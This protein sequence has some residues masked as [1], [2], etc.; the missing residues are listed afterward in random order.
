MI[1]KKIALIIDTKGWSFDYI[2][3]QVKKYIEEYDIDIIPG[4]IFN[5]NIAKLF[6]YCENYDL[7]HFMWRGYIS[8]IDSEMCKEY[9]NNLGYDYEYFKKKYILCKKISFQIP[10]Q[11]FLEGKDEWRTKKIMEYSKNYFVTSMNLQKIYN[12]FDIKPKKIIH[13]P[14]N[15]DLFNMKNESRFDK[16]ETLKLCWCGN[17]KFKDSTGDDDLKGVNGIIKPAV[18]ELQKE[19]YNIELD[20]IDREINGIP[21]EQMP[22]FY[23]N[24]HVYIC[25]SKTEGT[26]LTILEAMATGL[27]IISTDVG[28][29]REAL[30]KKQS[31]YILEERSRDCLKQKIIELINNKEEIKELSM[32][33]R[34]RI[35][36][37]NSEEIAKQYKGF[38][39][40]ILN[41]N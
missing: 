33:N 15:L 22:K 10:D 12:Q 37:F 30:G 34:K 41:N 18:E 29:V 6:L 4:N 16:I 17:S 8:M 24:E 19:G 40:E 28:I 27:A 20:L 32:E 35:K 36:C 38:F 25:A 23:N 26:P 14:V 2:A 1:K 39:E 3:N 31:K 13:D 21:R 7:V 9:S 5:G 11:L